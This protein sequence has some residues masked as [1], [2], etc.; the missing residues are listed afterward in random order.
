MCKK[1]WHQS[2]FISSAKVDL[3]NALMIQIYVQRRKNPRLSWLRI[4][5]LSRDVEKFT[6]LTKSVL[7][8]WSSHNSPVFVLLS[9]DLCLTWKCEKA[10]SIAVFLWMFLILTKCCSFWHVQFVVNDVILGNYDRIQCQ[11]VKSLSLLFLATLYRSIDT[12][13][14]IF[15]PDDSLQ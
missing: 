1:I 14:F 2:R 6:N 5:I 8:T 9:F 12:Q 7:A 15:D 10:G 11:N 3:T 4:L 13:S